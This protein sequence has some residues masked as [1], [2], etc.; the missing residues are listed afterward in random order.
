ML[1]ELSTLAPLF[2]IRGNID[3]RASDLPDI[4]TLHLESGDQRVLTLLMVHIALRGPKLMGEPVRL[5]REKGAQLLV[6]GHSHVPFVGRDKGLLV[7]NPGSV[8]PRRFQLPIVFGVIE[9]VAGKLDFY[10]VDAE[11]GERWEP[12]PVASRGV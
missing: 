5:A 8:G 3:V 11:S 1:D 7:F 2:M 12:W 6:C 10:H 4:L 9:L